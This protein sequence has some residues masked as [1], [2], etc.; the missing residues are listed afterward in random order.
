MGENKMKSINRNDVLSLLSRLDFD[1][2]PEREQR[3]LLDLERFFQK[4]KESAE[5]HLADLNDFAVWLAWE[6]K[7]DILNLLTNTYAREVSGLTEEKLSDLAEK[8]TKTISWSDVEKESKVAG[9]NA[10]LKKIDQYICKHRDMLLLDRV[11][12]MCAALGWKCEPDEDMDVFISRDDLEDG[13]FGLYLVC[14]DYIDNINE[15]A[16]EFDIANHIE[17]RLSANNPAYAGKTPVEMVR[18]AQKVQCELAK[19]AAEL[20]KLRSTEEF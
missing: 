5:T 19:L 2:L 3:A 20:N 11:V 17:K 16:S 8:I 7:P 10:I 14:P 6:G 1:V 18:Q 9:N 13:E 15:S 12:A 4:Q